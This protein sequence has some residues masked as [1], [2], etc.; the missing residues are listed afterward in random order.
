[1]RLPFLAAAF[2]ATSPLRVQD[3]TLVAARDNAIRAGVVRGLPGGVACVKQ[4][5]MRGD[6]AV[7]RGVRYRLPRLGELAD[8]LEYGLRLVQPSSLPAPS[9]CGGGAWVAVGMPGV[10][11]IGAPGGPPTRSPIRRRRSLSPDCECS[12]GRF[13]RSL[14]IL[15]QDVREVLP[16][17]LGE[18]AKRANGRIG[19]PPAPVSWALAS[20]IVSA[21][22]AASGIELVG[23][24]RERALLMRN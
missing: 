16:E 9:R 13:E 19:V 4:R 8:I 6:T 10:E 15:G 24:R 7:V 1:M 12:A 14:R 17:L 23:Q 18:G 5:V 3:T 11:R 22:G 20:V 21:V 2:V